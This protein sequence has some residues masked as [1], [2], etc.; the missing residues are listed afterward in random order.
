MGLDMYA[1]SVS[2][3][4]A[5]GDFECRTTSDGGDHQE[6]AYWRKFNALHGWMQDLYRDKG[7]DA[8]SFN[9][10]PVRLTPADLNALEEALNSNSL[11]PRE[12]FFFGA[13]DIYPEDIVSTRKFISD[14]RREMLEGK[15]VYYDSWW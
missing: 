9:C 6:I 11:R 7:G 12:G 4:N 8:E 14:A 1:F 15:E 13:Q 10:I 3:E 5:V 2:K